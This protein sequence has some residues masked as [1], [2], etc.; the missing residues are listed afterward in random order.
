MS[1][2]EERNNFNWKWLHLNQL[3][4]RFREAKC[5]IVSKLRSSSHF[6]W[7]KMRVSE[8]VVR[9][10]VQVNR[11]HGPGRRGDSWG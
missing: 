6:V 11:F 2:K 10:S 5:F 9:H 7:N 1:Q 8:I 3:S 4:Q